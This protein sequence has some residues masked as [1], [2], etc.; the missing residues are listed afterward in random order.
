MKRNMGTADRVIRFIIGVVALVIS[1]LVSSL[2]LQIVLW[3][4]AALLFVTSSL[5]VCPAYTLF[6]ISTK[7]K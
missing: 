7:K 1:F 3:V 6:H 4:V 2:A 5:G